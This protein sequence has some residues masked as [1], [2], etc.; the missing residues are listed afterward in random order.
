MAEFAYEQDSDLYVF[1][2]SPLA[3]CPRLTS[4][5]LELHGAKCR[6]HD[7]RGLAQLQVRLQG[8]ALKPGCLVFVLLLES[9]QLMAALSLVAEIVTSHILQHCTGC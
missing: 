5:L 8:H 9:L 6:Q 4:L 7:L 1:D 3:L 2:A